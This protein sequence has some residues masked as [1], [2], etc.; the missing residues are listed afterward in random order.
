MKA[1]PN[2]SHMPDILALE[3]AEGIMVLLLPLGSSAGSMQKTK[4]EKK[5]LKKNP[6]RNLSY[7]LQNIA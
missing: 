2:F 5:R 1:V 6:A 4:K 7:Y 3:L